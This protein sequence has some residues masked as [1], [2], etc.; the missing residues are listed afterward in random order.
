[1]KILFLDIDGVCNKGHCFDPSQG[2]R[3][4]Q[5]EL[6]QHLNEVV[7]QTDCRLV[8]SSAW[9]DYIYSGHYSLAGFGHMLRTHG[10][11]PPCGAA[12]V[13]VGVT[14]KDTREFGRCNDRAKQCKNWLQENSYLEITHYA[15]VDDVS[16]EFAKYDIPFVKTDPDVGLTEELANKLI[17][18]LEPQP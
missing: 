17:A 10:L 4:I 6:V 7:N 18:I 11:L 15:A 13:V 1:M 2:C 14:E 16:H 3:S 9:R 12:D 5:W 8:I